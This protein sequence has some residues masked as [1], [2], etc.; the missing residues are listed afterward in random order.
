MAIRLNL[1]HLPDLQAYWGENRKTM[2][3]TVRAAWA[4]VLRCYTGSEDICFGYDEIEVGGS[5][6]GVPKQPDTS[7][8]MSAARMIIGDATSFREVVERAKKG[9]FI[10]SQDPGMSGS[11]KAPRISERPPFNTAVVL[12]IHTNPTGA[13]A[14]AAFLRPTM[15]WALPEE[16]RFRRHA[17]LKRLRIDDR[18]SAGCDS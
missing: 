11:I 15:N 17:P 7:S 16:V 18:S 14:G 10:L 9:T 12:R 2:A 5:D 4:L 6:G 3:C 1:D 13:D 8:G